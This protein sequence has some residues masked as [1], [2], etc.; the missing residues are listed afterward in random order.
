[1][2]KRTERKNAFCGDIHSRKARMHV[3][4]SKELRAKAGV[5]MRSLLVNKGDTVK[6]MRGDSRGKSAKVARVSMAK[7]KVYLE[8]VSQRNRRGVESLLPFEPSNLVLT[9]MKDTPS[10][11][12]IL[13]GA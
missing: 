3:H 7:G 8:G 6:V 2:K 4:I 5:K 10:R 11:K 12:G 1:M 13:K 9:D